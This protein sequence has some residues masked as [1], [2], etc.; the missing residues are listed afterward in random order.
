MK[1]LNK[2]FSVGMGTNSEEFSKNWDIIFKKKIKT[3]DL[4]IYN[5]I[6]VEPNINE[7]DIN[8]EL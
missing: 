5:I 8:N 3:P 7:K 6:K 1:Y 2:T 4:E